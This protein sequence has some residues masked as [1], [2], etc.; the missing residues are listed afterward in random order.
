MLGLLIGRMEST[1]EMLW[2]TALTQG[3]VAEIYSCSAKPPDST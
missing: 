1:A 2:A 3:C